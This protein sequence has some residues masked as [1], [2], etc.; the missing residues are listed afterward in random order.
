MDTQGLDTRLTGDTVVAVSAGS[1]N[2]RR[3]RCRI[4]TCTVDLDRA[5]L[6]AMVCRLT[7]TVSRRF[8]AACRNRYR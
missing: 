3:R 1:I 2:L 7:G 8:L 6:V 4:A 5:V